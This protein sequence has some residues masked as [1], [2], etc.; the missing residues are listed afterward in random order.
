[1][2][3]SAY[4]HIKACIKSYLDSSRSYRVLDFGARTSRKQHLTHRELFRPL[5][6]EYVGL[7]VISG[8]NVD[9]VMPKP[10]TV[11]FD[12]ESFDVVVSG[13]VF[14]HVPF[15]WVSFLEM[16]R[17]V[18]VGGYIFLTAPSRGHIHSHPF[19]CW[20][21]YPD[22]YKALAAFA[23]LKLVEVHTDFPPRSENGRLDYAKV[24][25]Q[26]YWGDTVG[27]F[28]KTASYDELQIGKM[29]IPLQEW[30]NKVADINTALDSPRS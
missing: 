30:A 19:D 28:Q 9:V 1:M 8:D 27:V 22:G 15:F 17:V 18:K 5:K 14:E 3:R 7:D 20:R 13:Q 23:Q 11:P 21:F 6:A 12:N 2:H 29:R 16:A 25:P 4:E 10:Y 26:Q 24:P